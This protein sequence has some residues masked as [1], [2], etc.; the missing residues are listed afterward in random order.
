MVVGLERSSLLPVV[1][2]R[3][4]VLRPVSNTL[5]DQAGVAGSILVLPGGEVTVRVSFVTPRLFVTR[6][7][8]LAR[9]ALLPLCDAP[10]L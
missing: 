4:V 6:A 3:P 10:V 1:V 8:R 7:A 2:D 5:W 9:S